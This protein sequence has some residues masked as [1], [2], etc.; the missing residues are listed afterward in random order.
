LTTI[1]FLDSSA[2]IKL[3]VNENGSE[4][5]RGYIDSIVADDKA[6]SILAEVEVRSAL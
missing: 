6:F 5:L 1:H 3:F 2:L 4:R